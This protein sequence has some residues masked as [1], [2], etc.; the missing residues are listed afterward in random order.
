MR[1]TSVIWKGILIGL[2]GGILI[3]I[4]LYSRFSK[5]LPPSKQFVYK[6]DTVYEDVPYEVLKGFKDTTKPKTITYYIPQPFLDSIKI[7]YLEDSLKF[8]ISN[9]E[10]QVEIHANYLKQYPNAHKL[11]SL[12]LIRHNF[13]LTTLN[14]SGNT[15][16]NT[17]PLDLDN[18]Q[19]RYVNN[20]FS[21]IELK[22]PI[23]PPTL[24]ELY[25]PELWLGGRYDILNQHLFFNAELSKPIKY[26]R[27]GVAFNYNLLGS[28]KTIFLINVDYRIHKK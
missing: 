11:I 21:E 9:L 12:D 7:K 5:P 13:S 27:Y 26:M 19:Y 23:S 3:G 4:I 16:T 15:Q 20:F 24:W 28:P 10:G 14:I 8:I 22:N 18:F 17:W 25:K 1:N 6:T 2:I